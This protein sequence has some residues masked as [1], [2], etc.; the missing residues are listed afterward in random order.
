MDNKK[1][2]MADLL[3]EY[4]DCFD[5]MNKY[6][7][8]VEEKTEDAETQT[9]QEEIKKEPEQKDITIKC[10]KCEKDFIWTIKEQE[11]YKEKGFFR[12]AYCKDCRKKTRVVNNFHK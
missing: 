12:P 6:D 2:T 8:V 7:N 10:K 11:F 4:G 1:Y 5:K 3:A 9:I